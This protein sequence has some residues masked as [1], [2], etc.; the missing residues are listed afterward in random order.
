MLV[1]DIVP[2]SNV[3]SAVV[4]EVDTLTLVDALALMLEDKDLLAEARSSS[5]R[6]N[7]V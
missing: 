6:E 3:K 1:P 7:S 4:E 2:P 5:S